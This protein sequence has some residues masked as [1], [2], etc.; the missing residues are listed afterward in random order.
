[1]KFKLYIHRL[2]K[3]DSLG[4][5]VLT[6][7]PL[8]ILEKDGDYYPTDFHK[9]VETGGIKKQ[10]FY[11]KPFFHNII[12][13]L[14]YVYFDKKY[15]SRM[16]DLTLDMVQNYLI[17]YGT[18]KEMKK[19]T[20]ERCMN[21]IMTFLANYGRKNKDF[22][23][24]END[25]YVVKKKRKNNHTVNVKIPKFKIEYN[26]SN[27]TIFRDLPQKA[28]EIFYSHIFNNHKRI[29]MAVALQAFAGLRPSEALNVRR[30]DSKLGPGIMFQT[31]NG[32]INDITIDLSQEYVL[33]SDLKKTGGIKKERMQKVFVNFIPD[34]MDAYNE[35]MS[36]LQ[37]KKYEE[38]YGPLTINKQGKAML[39]A[40]YETEFKKAIKETIPLLL[41]SDD[42][43]VV[44]YGQVLQAN[45]VAL[46]ILR[47]YYTTRL[48]CDFNLDVP[49]LMYW[50]GDKSPESALTYLQNKSDLNKALKGRI[51]QRF[52]NVGTEKIS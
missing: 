12:S 3:M 27:R 32:V 8:I 11:N 28:F 14:N 18:R 51:D 21:D 35:Y 17:Y 40:T 30:A 1:M 41:Q 44:L 34:F 22:P 25:M 15:I 5:D 39:F 16:N 4:Y 23:I 10:G 2:V 7:I 48:V 13:F 26:P 46:H 50:R 52:A 36:Y 45:S 9:Y 19:T 38:A 37:G 47:H 31:V 6:E 42:P 33:R 49:D 43:E 24:K 20:A 29:L